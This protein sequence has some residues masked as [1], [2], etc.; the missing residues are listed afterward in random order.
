MNGVVVG[1]SVNQFHSH[2]FD[3]TSIAQL[4]N[5][6]LLITFT[7]P[8]VYGAA[9][10]KQVGDSFLKKIIFRE[11]I[12]FLRNAPSPLSEASAT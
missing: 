2:D 10:A 11:S 7:S 12:Q 8:V 1:R 9:Q 5:N 4:G 6:R 3:V